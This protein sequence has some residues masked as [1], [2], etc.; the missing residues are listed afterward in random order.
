MKL[1]N[2]KRKLVLLNLFEAIHLGLLQQ[3]KKCETP[4]QL[5]SMKTRSLSKPF[6][7]KTFTHNDTFL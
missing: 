1:R 4:V 5:K 6:H 3:G 7:Y 2:F